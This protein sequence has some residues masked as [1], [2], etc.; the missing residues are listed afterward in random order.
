MWEQIAANK[1]RSAFL[2]TLLFILMIALGLVIGLIFAPPKDEN[3]Q[4]WA[5]IG[6]II[7]G[8][9]FLIQYSV[10]ALSPQ[11]VVFSGFQVQEVKKED[12]PQLINV[13]EEMTIASGLGKMPRVYLIF[14]QAPNAFAF[15]RGEKASVAVTTGLLE[16]LDRD[17]L[18]GVIAHEIGHI[19]NRDI[20][21]MTLAAV[22]L[23]TIIVLSE[24]AYRALYVGARIGG[25]SSSRSSRRSSGGAEAIILLAALVFMVVAPLIAQLLYFA[26]SR[27]REYLADASAAIFT[28]YPEGLA[29]ALEK[30]A[31]SPRKMAQVNKAVAPLFIVNPF[32]SLNADSIFSTHPPVE[33]RIRILRSM[34]GASL[35]DYQ[36][37]AQRVLGRPI[38]RSR[39]AEESASQSMRAPQHVAETIGAAAVLAASDLHRMLGGYRM[40]TCPLCG[41]TIKVPPT[42][43]AETMTCPRC[44]HVIAL[45][46][47]G[48]VATDISKVGGSGLGRWDQAATRS[49]SIEETSVPTVAAEAAPAIPPAQDVMLPV[50][51]QRGRW[52]KLDCPICGQTIQLSPAFS[53]R[54][55][56]CPKCH[57]KLMF[58]NVELGASASA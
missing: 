5:V 28:R 30:I 53:A 52:Q 25:R 29:R 47:P 11:T 31:Y 44:G 33:K 7:G 50:A 46:P 51:R 18:Q 2:L 41:L 32:K 27:R 55:I 1:R 9:V 40:V 26:S 35:T 21:F 17:E 54:W 15:G 23:G 22:M 42:H 14:D 37:A 36:Q 58:P 19:R 34:A 3:D 48:V 45:P 12:I 24:I 38:L 4:Q 20:D 57:S 49:H 39:S 10:Y 16:M 13:V 6:F 8:I 56:R 43:E